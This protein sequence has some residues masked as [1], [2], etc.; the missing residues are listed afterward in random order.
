MSDWFILCVL[1]VKNKSIFFE[2]S[3]ISDDFIVF[4]GGDYKNLEF[5][6][7]VCCLRQSSV[8]TFFIV[9][10]YDYSLLV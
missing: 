4:A 3:L 8:I 1:Q 6:V 9:V 2:S 7:T 10:G 5:E